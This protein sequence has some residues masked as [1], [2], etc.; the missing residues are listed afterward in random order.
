ML[1]VVRR[2]SHLAGAAQ[3][4]K[5]KAGAASDFGARSLLLF[6]AGLSSRPPVAWSTRRFFFMVALATA[7]VARLLVD[8]RR[9]G[10]AERCPPDASR[11]DV[12]SERL[13]LRLGTDACAR[14]NLYPA[15]FYERDGSAP[16]HEN[17]EIPGSCS[18]SRTGAKF[19]AR[20]R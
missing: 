2:W 1:R 5:R 3:V 7:A 12:E 19:L 13:V 18:S 10:A 9:P 11:P 20:A 8:M 6:G 14:F 16:R 17:A 4:Q 15:P